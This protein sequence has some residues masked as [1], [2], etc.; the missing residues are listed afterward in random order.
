[1]GETIIIMP[2]YNETE[3]IAETIAPLLSLGY[4]VVV[5][6]DGSKI[7]IESYIKN[8]KVHFLG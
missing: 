6:D 3:V 8:Q 1:M 7:N 5:V 2:A 4:E